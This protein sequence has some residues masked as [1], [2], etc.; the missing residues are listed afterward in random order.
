[1]TLPAGV[2]AQGVC[3]GWLA[4]VAAGEW[5]AA[6]TVRGAIHLP[7][8]PAVPLLLVGPGTGVAPFRAFL[9]HRRHLLRT[10]AP[11]TTCHTFLNSSGR[12]VLVKPAID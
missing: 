1:M 10:S 4:G 12:A 8:C 9:H 7:P 3:T 6:W 11:G 2:T 5:V